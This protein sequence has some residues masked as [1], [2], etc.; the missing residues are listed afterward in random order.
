MFCFHILSRSVVSSIN[1]TGVSQTF[2]SFIKLR[3]GHD[4]GRFQQLKCIKSKLDNE[5]D[6]K[7]Q[8]IDP[9]TIIE[10]I[11]G[12]Q[13]KVKNSYVHTARWVTANTDRRCIYNRVHSFEKIR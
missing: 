3:C 8:L 4:F 9:K 1:G 2:G 5:T 10:T 7:S 12:T 11:A 13:I 6:V